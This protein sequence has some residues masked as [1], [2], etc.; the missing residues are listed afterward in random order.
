MVKRLFY[1]CALAFAL[2]FPLR[3]FATPEYAQQTGL[4]CRDCHIEATGG[5]PLTPAGEKFLEDLKAKGLQRQLSETQKVV[6][7]IVGYFHMMA[8][9][10]WFGAILYVHILLKPAY[11]AK[12]IPRGELSL[13]WIS[14]VVV[15]VTGILLTIA[16]VP[17]LK[18][19]YTTRFGILLGIKILLF[20]VMFLSALIVT[21]YIGPRLRKQRAASMGMPGGDMT[22]DEL[23]RC[24][25]QEGR[26]AYIAYK[27]VVYDISQSKL[28]K[29][30]SHMR[31]H[32][33]GSDLTDALRTAPHGED[34]IISMPVIGRL[35]EP[36][37]RPARPFHERLFYFFAYMNLTLTF[38]IVFDISLWRWWQ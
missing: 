38:L 2:F 27:G 12:G 28:W 22:P 9:F 23:S 30:G 26:P 16:R 18:V 29:D 34:K 21:V 31:K 35:V 36:A 6:H 24:D 13:G 33:A 17:S 14:M 4:L 1:V 8:A 7:L 10:T 20:T 15:L 37:E 11:A 25:G 32:L 3:S 5:G 19:F